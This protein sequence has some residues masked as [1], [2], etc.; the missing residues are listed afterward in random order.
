MFVDACLS[1][2]RKLEMST[3]SPDDDMVTGLKQYRLWTPSA[4][5]Y[6]AIVWGIGLL[7]VTGHLGD[8]WLYACGV[9]ATNMLMFYVIKCG[10]SAADVRVT[11][12]RAVL[13]GER[14]DYLNQR[15]TSG[16]S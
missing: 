6:A 4:I 3:V 2:A 14:V 12:H 8:E 1:K 15:Q 13:A 10:I 5:F 11:L 9:I 7:I 16:S